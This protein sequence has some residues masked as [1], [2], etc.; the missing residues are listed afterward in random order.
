[1][2]RSLQKKARAK[3]GLFMCILECEKKGTKV[4]SSFKRFL[5]KPEKNRKREGGR[6]TSSYPG[7]EGRRI[8]VQAKQNHRKTKRKSGRW[9][10]RKEG[11]FSKTGRRDKGS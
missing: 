7:R 10:K 3:D 2:K 5:S 9:W 1:L 6:E 11:W 4:H 8:N